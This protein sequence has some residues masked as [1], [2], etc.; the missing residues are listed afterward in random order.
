MPK[1]N[2]NHTTTQITKRQWLFLLIN[3]HGNRIERET[4]RVLWGVYP[5]S[6]ITTPMPTEFPFKPPSFSGSV[7]MR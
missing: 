1:A 4:L 5:I 3:H 6:R 2:N 7:F